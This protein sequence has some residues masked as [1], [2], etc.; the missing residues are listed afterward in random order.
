[1]AIYYGCDIPEDLF[2]HLEYD[3]WVRFEDNNT[4]T[5]GMVDVAQ[6]AAGKLL[7]IQFKP[8]GKKVRAGRSAA[9]IESSKWVGPFRMPFDVEILANNLDAFTQDVLI[10]NKDPYRAGWLVKVRLL[11]PESARDNLAT[12]AEAVAHYKQRIDDNDIRCFRCVDEP[13]PMKMEE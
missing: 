10:A 2:Y 13:A 3:V 11:H 12:G 7:F 5:L 6:T 1:M 9:T 4:A 8:A